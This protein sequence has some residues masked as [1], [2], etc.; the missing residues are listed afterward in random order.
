[1]YKHYDTLRRLALNGQFAIV[2]GDFANF[3]G[4]TKQLRRFPE[5]NSLRN[6]I[7]STNIA[8]ILRIEKELDYDNLLTVFDNGSNV[9]VDALMGQSEQ[10]ACTFDL[11]LQGINI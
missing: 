2:Y 8:D 3:L 4:R 11:L 1:M 9:F 6:V 5:F 10:P 7:Y